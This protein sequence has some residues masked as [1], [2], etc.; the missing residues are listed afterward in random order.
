MTW[1][2]VH[3]ISEGPMVQS[4]NLRT[5]AVTAAVPVEYYIEADAYFT[6]D[7]A[8]SATAGGVGIPSDG[9]S[10]STSR[11]YCRCAKR[12]VK[13]LSPVQ[14]TVTCEFEDLTDGAS[15][16]A[17]VAQPARITDSCEIYTQAYV[18]DAQGN[19]VVNKAG[20]PFENPPQRQ[21]A[22]TVYNIKKYVNATT[23]AAIDTAWNTNNNAAITIYGTNW[24][25][26]EGWIAERSFAPVD[27]SG[28]ILEATIVVKCKRGGWKDI[29]LNVGYRDITGTLIKR[30]IDPQTH[31]TLPCSKPWPL[32]SSGYAKGSVEYINTAN[33]ALGYKITG[34]IE[35]EELELWPYDR[36]AWTGVP[37]S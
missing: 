4:T 13:R 12:T 9:S 15:S 24:A 5:G 27:G 7:Q 28:S 30:E 20:D 23:R 21:V 8:L 29:C 14:G 34:D 31:Q 22:V 33:K 1:L 11:P 37:L 16:I 36:A 3:V 26:D 18:K 6:L 32:D 10:Y 2:D 19:K 35:P 25:V 17:L